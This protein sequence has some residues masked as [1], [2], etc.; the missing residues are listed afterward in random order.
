MNDSF[1]QSGWDFVILVAPML[2]LLVLS[3]FRLDQFLARP[4]RGRRALNLSPG[5]D[6]A[7]FD[8]DGRPWPLQPPASR[9]PAARTE[10]IPLSETC[11]VLSIR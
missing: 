11:H 1:Y 10:E 3:S 2:A 8:P 4:H 9:H 6:G 7:G 5:G